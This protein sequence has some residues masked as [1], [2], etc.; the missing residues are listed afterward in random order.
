MNTKITRDFLLRSK[1]YLWVVGSVCQRGGS[2]EIIRI[3]TAS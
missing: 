2:G 3:G 1:F